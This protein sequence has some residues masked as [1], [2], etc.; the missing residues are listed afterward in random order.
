M[1]RTYVHGYNFRENNRLQDQATTLVDLL[2]SD[3]SYSAGSHGLLRRYD[4]SRG[5]IKGQRSVPTSPRQ[6]EHGG[7]RELVNRSGLL[8]RTH[9]ARPN[10]WRNRL[11][12]VHRLH[13]RG[14]KSNNRARFDA[15]LL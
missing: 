5:W 2:H 3:T 12:V 7:V 6:T 4:E 15:L 13:F 14:P 11:I 1:A 10:A 9:P 8:S